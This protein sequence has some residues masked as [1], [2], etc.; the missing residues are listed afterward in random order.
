MSEKPTDRLKQVRK[1]HGLTQR[2]A[3]EAIGMIQQTWGAMESGR[4]DITQK[5]AITIHKTWG[6]DL[7]WLFLGIG[8][9]DSGEGSATSSLQKTTIPIIPESELSKLEEGNTIDPGKIQG[10][11]YL[12]EIKGDKPQYAIKVT[13]RNMEPEIKEGS[14]ILVEEMKDQTEFKDSRPYVVLLHSVPFIK[15]IN[16][17]LGGEDSGKFRISS[18]N[19]KEDQVIGQEEIDRWYKVTYVINPV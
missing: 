2:E 8:S 15:R 9:I 4:S 5:T 7:N 1:K 17:I 18:N 3:A 16:M 12:S 14:I 11:V 10:E 19:E 13:S 6:V